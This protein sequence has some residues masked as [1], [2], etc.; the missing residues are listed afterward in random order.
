MKLTFFFASL[1][2]TAFAFATDDYV[3]G[4]DSKPQDGVPT[5]EVLKFEFANSK[6]FPGT[7]RDYWVYVP[8]QYTPDKRACVHVNQ[9]GVQFQAPVV[10][11]NLIA[12]KELPVIIGV[13]VIRRI[14]DIE[15]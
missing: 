12:K 13:F 10:F 2:A 14:V 8:S 1:L 4:P 5:G 15:V 11:D 7:V 3:P 9:D 6:I